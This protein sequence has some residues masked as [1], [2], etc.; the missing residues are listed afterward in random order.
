MGREL[1][2]YILYGR[3]KRKVESCKR[4][5]GKIIILLAGVEGVL[6]DDCYRLCAAGNDFIS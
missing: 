1:S 3:N 5:I 4:R 2:K 6:S